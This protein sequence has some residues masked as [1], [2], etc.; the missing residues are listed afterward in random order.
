MDEVENQDLLSKFFK[1]KM[2]EYC[3]LNFVPAS[4]M[5][6]MVEKYVNTNE[7]HGLETFFD[8]EVFRAAYSEI[9][10]SMLDINLNGPVRKSY[11]DISEEIEKKMRE[12]VQIFLKK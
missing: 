1:Q 10:K 5:S 3:T 4:R 2:N 9:K 6:A 11:R 8:H 7:S 12:K